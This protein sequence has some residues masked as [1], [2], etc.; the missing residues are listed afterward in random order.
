VSWGQDIAGGS[1][2]SLMVSPSEEVISG[3]ALTLDPP[4][5]ASESRCSAVH[6]L[7]CAVLW[8]DVLLNT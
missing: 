4:E 1:N 6:V 5:A 2:I 7:C 8:C 3:L